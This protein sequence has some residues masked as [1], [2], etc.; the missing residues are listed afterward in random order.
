MHLKFVQCSVVLFIAVGWWL[1][2]CIVVHF[3]SWHWYIKLSRNV[4]AAFILLLCNCIDDIESIAD[5]IVI[6]I[7]NMQL[8]VLQIDHRNQLHMM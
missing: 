8:M 5:Y 4:Y 2:F 6:N 7:G 3:Y 1:S